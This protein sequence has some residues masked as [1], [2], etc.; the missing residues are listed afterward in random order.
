MSKN[1]IHIT[2]AQRRALGLI[3][4]LTTIQRESLKHLSQLT[5]RLKQLRMELDQL[6][7]ALSR[8]H[9]E[10]NALELELKAAKGAYVLRSKQISRTSKYN[11]EG[12][13]TP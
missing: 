7:V 4:K 8:K 6:S 5:T 13:P 1:D 2:T 3:P 11:K 10:V 9:N 12:G